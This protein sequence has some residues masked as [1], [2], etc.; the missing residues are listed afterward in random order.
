MEEGEKVILYSYKDAL[1]IKVNIANRELNRILVDQKSSVDIFFKS[2]LD[3]MGIADVR[4]K[5]INIS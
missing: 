3:E 5:H 2:I 4:V 1:V